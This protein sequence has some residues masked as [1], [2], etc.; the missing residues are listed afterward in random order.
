M[1]DDISI[2]QIVCTDFYGSNLKKIDVLT[3]SCDKY[4]E[5]FQH[6]QM[7]FE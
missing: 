7:A 4:V 5:T 3:E 2:N 6:I 1:L